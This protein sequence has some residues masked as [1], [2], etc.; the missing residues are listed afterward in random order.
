MFSFSIVTTTGEG[1]PNEKLGIVFSQVL[2]DKENG[3][4]ALR[5][6]FNLAVSVPVAPH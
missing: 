2:P 6:C 3:R 1:N 5:Q 4:A